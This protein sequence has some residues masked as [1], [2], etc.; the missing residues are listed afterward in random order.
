MNTFQPL[1]PQQRQTASPYP[2]GMNAPGLSPQSAPGVS[3]GAMLGSL[4][5]DGPQQQQKLQL[6]QQ[7]HLQQQQLQQQHF[8]EQQRQLWMAQQQQRAGQVTNQQAQAPQPHL[9]S[10]QILPS[11]QPEAPEAA[12]TQPPKMALFAPVRVEQ[13]LNLE[14]TAEF[15]KHAMELQAQQP[16]PVDE[17]L[18]PR[19]R[20]PKPPKPPKPVQPKT[21]A[22]PPT[23]KTEQELSQ[24]VSEY[25]TLTE[26]KKQLADWSRDVRDRMQMCERVLKP[27]LNAGLR[28]PLVD[29]VLE[30]YSKSTVSRDPID[31]AEAL[32]RYFLIHFNMNAEEAFHHACSA[33]DYQKEQLPTRSSQVMRRVTWK[34]KRGFTRR[35]TGN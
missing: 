25:V 22:P 30:T 31:M 6:Q 32:G 23:A 4:S 29:G 24:Y 5:I 15:L 13:I 28:V 27:H 26:Q 16:P 33:V 11:Q 9:S 2:S 7:L 17:V 35:R 10:S 21:R 20:V 8:Q 34:T 12:D 3:P 18:A 19:V 1:F 14:G